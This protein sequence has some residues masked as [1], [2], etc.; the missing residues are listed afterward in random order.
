MSSRPA[1]LTLAARSGK[2]PVTV[3]NG[4]D[5]AVTMQL[6]VAA[7]PAVRL[8]LTQPARQRIPAGESRTFEVPAEATTN[9]NVQLVVRLLTPDGK[10][11]GSAVSFPV[12][13]T[14]FGAVAQI[15]VGGAF[16]LL[17]A[18]LVFRVVRAIRRGR[19]AGF[20][21]RRTGARRE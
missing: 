4:L 21:R 20:A 8:T 18:T 17:A 12:Q 10:P 3:E 11:Y 2:I 13:I 19:A 15:V 16:V 14:G 5:Q 7:D 1:P 6:S 9:G